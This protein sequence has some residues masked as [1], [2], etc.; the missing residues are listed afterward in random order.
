VYK[1]RTTNYNEPRIKQV[2]CVV[3]V[4]TNRSPE[5]K[6][7]TQSPNEERGQAQYLKNKLNSNQNPSS[8]PTDTTTW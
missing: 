6:S 8:T 5:Q 7:P 3:L 1:G 4:V 2:K